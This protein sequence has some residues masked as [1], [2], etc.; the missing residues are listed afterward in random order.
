MDRIDYA[1]EQLS[2]VVKDT[3][4]LRDWYKRDMA[5]NNRRSRLSSVASVTF[6]ALVP[7]TAI[8]HTFDWSVVAGALGAAAAVIGGTA[9]VYNWVGS[10]KDSSLAEAQLDAAITSW[11]LAVAAAR[12]NADEAAGVT[13]LMAA[14]G[15]LAAQT[16]AVRLKETSGF[17][18]QLPQKS[19]AGAGAGGTPPAAGAEPA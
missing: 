17:F 16:A 2:A 15:Q 5:Y 19:A 6:A 9:A 4:D 3:E 1:L 13:S 7:F 8:F 18:N 12:V 11:K 10:W 14:G